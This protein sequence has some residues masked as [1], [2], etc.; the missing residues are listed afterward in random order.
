M[1]RNTLYTLIYF[2]FI[3]NII[4]FVVEKITA[5]TIF[6]KTNNQ[7]DMKKIKNSALIILAAAVLSSCGGLNKMVKEAD[8]VAYKVTPEVLEMHG[9][10]VDVAVE[11]SYPAKYFNKKAILTLTPVVKYAGGET[12]LKKIVVQGEDVTENNKVINFTT[13]GKESVSDAFEYADEMM[14]SELVVKISAD[15]KGKTADFED[16]KLADGIIATPNL[17]EVD[18]KVLTFSDNFKRIVP[19]AYETDI[20]YVINRADVRKSEIQKEGVVGLTDFLKEA[21][22]ND[23]IEL[24]NLEISAYASPDGKLEL[25]DKLSKKRETSADKYLKSTLKKAKVDV[26]E[27]LLSLL[28]TPE[29]WDGFKKLM[30]ASDIQDKEMILRVLSMHSDPDV[31]EQEIKNI[32]AAFEEIKVKILPELRRSKFTVNVDKIGWSDDELKELWT[33]NPDKLNLE[34]LLY[35][36]TLVEDLDT[37]AAVYKKATMLSPKCLRAH[38]NLG[39]TLFEMGKIDAAEASL[40]AAK[41]IKDNDIVNNNL[42]AVALVKND[43]EK[44]SELFTS[45]LGAG[46]DVNYNLG[47]VNIIEGDYGKALNYLGSEPSY[48]KALALYL[49]K[50][51]EMGFR[52][53][54][55]LTDETAKQYYLVAVIASSQKKDDVALENL[56]VAVSK[57]A[58]LKERA[59][60]DLEFAGLFENADFKAIVQ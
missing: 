30:E 35:T 51:D 33:S 55:N 24:K 53:A 26:A 11:V 59:K 41:E 52:T 48:N 17:V 5:K 42:G 18:P 20:K 16:V 2:N 1:Y 60:K 10:E 25:N 32:S 14:L 8:Q 49:D 58:S 22:A 46:A 37:K 19:D 29:D 31:R 4:K 56:K 39:A 54:V 7:I 9:G 36:A 44:A 45:A 40:M 27:E 3:K 34:E 28:A 21:T 50:N 13:G 15:L 38:N 6:I 23:R 12:E 47:I 43:V 57:D